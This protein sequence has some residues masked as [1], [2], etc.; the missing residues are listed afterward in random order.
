MQDNDIRTRVFR[1]TDRFPAGGGPHWWR[2]TLKIAFSL[3]Q[4]VVHL[5]DWR[6][7]NETFCHCFY[8]ERDL[9][10][11]KRHHQPK[12]WSAQNTVTF[13]DVMPASISRNSAQRRWAID[14]CRSI[15]CR[16]QDFMALFSPFPGNL[17]A[18]ADVEKAA[19]ETIPSVE[20]QNTQGTLFYR[21]VLTW[22]LAETT[23][24]ST[25]M[26]PVD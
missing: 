26:F 5:S 12:T 8:R 25:S 22:L 23:R 16:Y 9:R 18:T 15:R 11:P 24:P 20:P 21:Q 3:D 2:T 4:W 7:T 10:A 6:A 19:S 14:Q 17:L 1:W 13:P